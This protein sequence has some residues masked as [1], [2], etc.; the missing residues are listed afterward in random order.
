VFQ[1]SELTSV[2]SV[3][4]VRFTKLLNKILKIFVTFK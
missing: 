2:N 4:G 1:K 3:P